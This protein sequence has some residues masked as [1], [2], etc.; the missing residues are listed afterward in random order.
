MVNMPQ[1]LGLKTLNYPKSPFLTFQVLYSRETLP[2]P[3]KGFPSKKI[4]LSP[5]IPSLYLTLSLPP[6]REEEQI[7]THVSSVSPTFVVSSVVSIFTTHTGSVKP[8]AYCSI[9]NGSLGSSPLR[10]SDSEA[11]CFSFYTCVTSTLTC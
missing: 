4:S 2:F 6:P 3:C 9:G 1:T 10:C 5:T 7:W 11:W 8:S